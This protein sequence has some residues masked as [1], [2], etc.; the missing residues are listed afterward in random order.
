M[1]TVRWTFVIAILVCLL[2]VISESTALIAGNLAG[3]GLPGDEFFDCQM[4]GLDVTPLLMSLVSLER[5]ALGGVLASLG[6]VLA[7]VIAE[8]VAMT[9]GRN[10]RRLRF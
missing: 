8:L 6:M 7:W 3:C 4:R 5:L 10:S 9:I 1:R 2:P